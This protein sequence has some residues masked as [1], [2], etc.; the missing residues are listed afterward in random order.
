METERYERVID[1]LR[2]FLAEHPDDGDVWMYM[3]NAAIGLGDKER[4][5]DFLNKGRALSGVSLSLD[6]PLDSDQ[7]DVAPIRTTIIRYPAYPAEMKEKGIEGR[8]VAQ[9]TVTPT[10]DVTEI[11]IESATRPEFA[12]AVLECLKDWTYTPGTKNGKPVSV[13]MSLPFVFKPVA[14]PEVSQQ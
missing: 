8:V 11:E 6:S 9:F 12:D 4:A 10:G 1:I 14:K 7:Y 5:A 3:A 13:R 2:G